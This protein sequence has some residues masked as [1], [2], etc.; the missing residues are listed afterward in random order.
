MAVVREKPL[1]L[2]CD[3]ESPVRTREDVLASVVF[4][5]AVDGLGELVQVGVKDSQEALEGV[6]ADAPLT[7]LDAA[8]QRRVG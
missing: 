4:F 2:V 1:D 5:G 7:A 3:R 8:Y 6:P